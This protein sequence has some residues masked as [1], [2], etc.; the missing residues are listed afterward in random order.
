M[1]IPKLFCALKATQR[2]I[3]SLYFS[4]NRTKS[5][6][7]ILK[8]SFS[9]RHCVYRKRNHHFRH[10]HRNRIS[11]NSSTQTSGWPEFWFFL[12]TKNIDKLRI[13]PSRKTSYNGIC[14]QYEPIN[15]SRTYSGLFLDVSVA[16]AWNLVA[17]ITNSAALIERG[18]KTIQL[19]TTMLVVIFRAIIDARWFLCR[20]KQRIGGFFETALMTSIEN[21]SMIINSSFIHCRQW[22]VIFHNM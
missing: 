18:T 13:K 4:K 7:P 12:S 21:V 14:Y 20:E 16:M 1:I 11:K 8:I 22:H 3:I 17:V 2:C 10:A 19:S 6:P 9:L 15:I 5:P